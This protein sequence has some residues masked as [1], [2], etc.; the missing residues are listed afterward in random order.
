M[1]NTY[2]KYLHKGKF[3]KLIRK[4]QNIAHDAL[5]VYNEKGFEIT[6]VRGSVGN[7]VLGD[8]SYGKINLYAYSSYYQLEIGRYT[9]ISDI[10]I[11]IGGNHH[12]DVTTYPFRNRFQ[13][14]LIE[15]DNFAPR[16]VKIG[17][18]VWIGYGA[19]IL[20]GANIGTGAIIGAGTVIRGNVPPYAVVIGNPGTIIKYRFNKVEIE[21][22]MKSKWWELPGDSLLKIENLSYS[23]D[24]ETFV[25]KVMELKNAV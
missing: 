23:K 18:D 12:S 10:S 6:N 8:Y 19:I 17:H 7:L 24:V 16:P 5:L 25:S 20:D 13:G 21:K 14:T 22:L 1:K 3:T 2:N 4:F 9:S 15:N 11:I